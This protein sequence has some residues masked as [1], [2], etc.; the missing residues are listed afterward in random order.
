MHHTGLHH[1]L[2]EAGLDRLGEA[3]EPVH[4]A[5]QDVFHTPVAE[6][7]EHPSPKLRALAGLHP[8]PEDMLNPIGVDPDH[9]VGGLVAH[10][11]GIL[12]LHPHRVAVHDRIHRVQRSGLPGLHLLSD[13]LGDVGDCFVAQ[14]GTQGALQVGLNIPNRH[15]T[16]IQADDHVRQAANTARAFSHQPRLERPSAVP[17]GGQ[18]DIADL[19]AQPFRG[20]PIPRIARSVTGS[21]MLLIAQMVGELSLQPG[22]Q[23]PLH[24]LRQKPALTS[25][26]H[27]IPVDAGHQIV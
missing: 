9:D 13:R 27:P 25:Q 19:S 26:L 5:D 18:V 8:N 14:L 7:G 2:R 15:P 23:N 20:E 6:L 10:L 17:W 1:R 16:R 4:A 22:L 12:D 24:Q 11:V 21:V 3:G